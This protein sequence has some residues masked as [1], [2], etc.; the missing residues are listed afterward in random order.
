MR[1][2]VRRFLQLGAIALGIGLTLSLPMPGQ[3]A[4]LAQSL[5]QSEILSE[6]LSS[7]RVQDLSRLRPRL[8][9]RVRPRVRPRARPDDREVSIDEP[10]NEPVVA[11]KP[12]PKQSPKPVVSARIRPKAR[13]DILPET[14]LAV[15][16]PPAEPTKPEKPATPVQNAVVT[17]DPAPVAAAPAQPVDLSKVR[18]QARPQISQ[19][20]PE[21]VVAARPASEPGPEQPAVQ[22]EIPADV[23]FVASLA[24]SEE[25]ADL[26]QAEAIWRLIPLD[27][28]G[29]ETL[30][31]EGTGAVYAVVAPTG[32]YRI[33][34]RLGAVSAER[35]V[36]LV[37][38]KRTTVR[39]VLNAGILTVVPKRMTADKAAD[40]QISVELRGA[41]GAR[42]R[43]RGKSR[44]IVPAGR[45]DVTVRLGKAEAEESLE[46][47]PGDI[48]SREL[49]LNTATVTGRILLTMDGKP[50]E[51]RE[52]KFDIRTE[53]GDTRRG[54]IE[55]TYGARP[56]LVSAG[57][58]VLRARL[59]QAQAQSQ[60]FALKPGEDRTVDIV[61][62][63][64]RLNVS[65]P[66]SYRVSVIAGPKSLE[67][68]REVASGQGPDFAE[69][70][71]VGDYFLALAYEGGKESRHSFRIA[72][73][74][75]TKLKIPAP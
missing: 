61:L 54:A 72:A 46:L 75:A 67:A 44:F 33:R 48:I 45:V 51:T 7:P 71:P 27:N 21:K 64:G 28:S 17:P 5:S 66:G 37:A 68:G 1:F 56:M 30:P 24:L 22:T 23:N 38:A 2:L 18:P 42:E 11:P 10:A 26:D 34:V 50:V 29:S 13:P 6:T 55:K 70:L 62:E 58:Y 73:G 14:Q 25:S 19:A 57:R 20:A 74:K 15:A 35:D 41:Q 63:A 32:L 3:G 31:E 40:P 47:R 43:S 9:L 8:R 52:A 49:A 36:T 65:A 16:K 53:A 39:M 12:R 69:V 59:G 4:A 60:G